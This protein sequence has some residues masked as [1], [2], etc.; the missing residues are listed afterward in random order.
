MYKVTIFG[1]KKRYRKDVHKIGPTQENNIFQTS[2]HLLHF[3]K[4]QEKF[5]VVASA[6]YN[7][8]H[9]Y[10]SA[11]PE[12]IHMENFWKTSSWFLLHAQPVLQVMAKIIT[13]KWSHGERIVHYYFTLKQKSSLIFANFEAGQHP[14]NDTVVTS[15]S[16]K[17]SLIVIPD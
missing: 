7:E 9:L 1:G 8:Q 3:C 2:F 11:L 6:H 5:W 12:P 10:L 16:R 14:V 15:K 4:I 17:P 13:E